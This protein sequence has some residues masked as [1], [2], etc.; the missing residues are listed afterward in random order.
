MTTRKEMLE[1]ADD[2][3]TDVHNMLAAVELTRPDRIETAR[4]IL[5]GFER[6]RYLIRT[7]KLT[8][9]DLAI[10]A[11]ILCDSDAMTIGLMG[12]VQ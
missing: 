5:R 9:R 1:S 12:T 8:G 7:S 11:E 3:I 6:A 4:A 2:L 10:I